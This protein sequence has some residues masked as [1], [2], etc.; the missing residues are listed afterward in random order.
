[1]G[2][3]AELQDG[4]RQ[5]HMAPE[6]ACRI[7]YKGD[8]SASLKRLQLMNMPFSRLRSPPLFC[9]K[10]THSTIYGGGMLR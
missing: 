9:H 5:V 4:A 7:N 2:S 6:V 1:M 8:E 10:E 3:T